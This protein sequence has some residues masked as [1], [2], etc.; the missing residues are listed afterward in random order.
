MVSNP[1]STMV[2]ASP[3]PQREEVVPRGC[4]QRAAMQQCSKLSAHPDRETQ[5]CQR[6]LGKQPAVYSQLT[7]QVKVN[8]KYR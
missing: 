4:S 7:L 3:I 2:Y 1:A 5:V 8:Q 6:G